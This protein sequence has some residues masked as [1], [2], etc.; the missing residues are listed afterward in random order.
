MSWFANVRQIQD[1]LPQHED[2]TF[3]LSEL[4]DRK[5]KLLQLA[6]KTLNKPE[7]KKVPEKKEDPASEP[8]EDAK[9]E[10]PQENGDADMKEDKTE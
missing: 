1:S 10:V 4:S 7:P 9:A 2:P 3:E 5:E 6:D 8:K